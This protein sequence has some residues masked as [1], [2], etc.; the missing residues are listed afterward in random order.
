LR[1]SIARGLSE[2]G[3]LH[4]NVPLREPLAHEAPLP[5]AVPGIQAFATLQKPMPP[6]SAAQA[7]FSG[8]RQPV[9]VAGPGRLDAQAIAGLAERL[10]AP[11]LAEGSSALRFGP[12][13]RNA[14]AH[15]EALLRAEAAP[16]PDLIVRVGGP[17]T[18]RVLQGFVDRSTAPVLTLAEPGR[19]CDPALRS[20]LVLEGDTGAI[21]NALQPGVPAEKAWLERW[22]SLD[23]KAAHALETAVTGEPAFA[24][25]LLAALPQGSNL[26]LS[27]SMPIRDVDA[28]ASKSSRALDVF[29][30]RGASGIDGITST[31]FGIAAATGRKTTLYV[32]D[33]ALLHDA[34]GLLWGSRLGL[35]LCV[36]AVNNAG[37]RIF[38]MLPVAQ[39]T[40]KLDALFVMP[41]GADLERLAALANA[42]HVRLDAPAQVERA[43]AQGLEGG[44]HV[45]ELDARNR[46]VKADHDRAWTAVKE[47]VS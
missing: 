19:V 8:A 47:A 39:L 26:M 7:L 40:Q 41:P 46:D 16:A 5:G 3:V 4:L 10:G 34:G 36:V 35:S 33:T 20:T 32:G 30:S 45:V 24:R 31:A 14:V 12:A 38:E 1:S 11:I 23:T 2:R 25:A 15:Y 27:N 28:F 44:V 29:T 43:V 37:G 17:L 42:H 6:V 22:L 9:V 13:G 18:T 21:A